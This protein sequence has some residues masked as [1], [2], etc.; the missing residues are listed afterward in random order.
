MNTYGQWS[1]FVYPG[2]YQALAYHSYCGS[3][4]IFAWLMMVD[5]FGNRYFRDCISDILLTVPSFY[6]YYVHGLQHLGG[7]S[8]VW[9]APYIFKNPDTRKSEADLG[10]PSP[11]SVKDAS[12][13]VKNDKDKQR[14]PTKQEYRKKVVTSITKEQDDE[15]T[16]KIF[17]KA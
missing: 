3:V 6:F 13:G 7:G 17:V 4:K 5:Y 11:T 8:L 9:H 10:G 12:F 2:N 1:L 14:G 15:V 16:Q